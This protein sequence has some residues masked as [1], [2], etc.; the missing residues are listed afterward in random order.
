M[1]EDFNNV[2][3]IGR[4]TRT[5]E[6]KAIGGSGISLCQFS[7][8]VNDR[9]REDGEYCNFFDCNLWGKTAEAL[10]PYLTQGQQIAIT[11]SLKQSRWEKDGQ[12]RSKVEINVF[13]L[14]FL[15]RPK[16]DGKQ[17]TP[18]P[19]QQ[20]GFNNFDSDIPF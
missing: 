9:K 12:K 2:S 7:I 6:L 5:P 16:D 18:A 20:G 10:H 13:K 1:A 19:Q 14:Q 17:P 4:I 11:G 3:A 15:Q 8:A